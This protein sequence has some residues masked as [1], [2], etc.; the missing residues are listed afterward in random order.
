MGNGIFY[1]GKLVATEQSRKLDG[2]VKA[3]NQTI[4]IFKGTDALRKIMRAPQEDFVQFGGWS[5][6]DKRG[7]V[8]IPD[9]IK[10]LDGSL[11]IYLSLESQIA[12][13][14]DSTKS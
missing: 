6:N 8:P 12:N 9:F 4:Y 1:K 7:K 10:M 13:E 11:A 3:G 2:G 14:I 5:P